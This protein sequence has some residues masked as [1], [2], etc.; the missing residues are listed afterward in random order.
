MVIALAETVFI[1][2]GEQHD[3]RWELVSRQAPDA[4]Q[5][6]ATTG[7]FEEFL[8]LRERLGIEPQSPAVRWTAERLGIL[9]A[10][11]PAVAEKAKGT[12]LAKRPLI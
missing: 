10:D 8:R 4:A 6:A 9:K 7:A 5:S 2:Q 12:P 11:L 1:G 3:L